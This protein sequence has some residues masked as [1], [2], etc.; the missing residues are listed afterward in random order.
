MITIIYHVPV[1]KKDDELE[2]LR[3]QK[4]FPGIQDTWDWD[5]RLPVVQFACIVSP[6]A[7]MTIKLRHKLDIQVDY[8]QR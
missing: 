4:I 5:T 1:E 7:A 6:A 3:D 2:W 8:K